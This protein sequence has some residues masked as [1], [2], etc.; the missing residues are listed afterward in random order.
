M[1][2]VIGVHAWSPEEA[3]EAGKRWQSGY[4]AWEFTNVRPVTVT[5][6]AVARRHIYPLALA[7]FYL[8]PLN[9]PGKF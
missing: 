3:A 7:K 1:I 6:K 2:D 9:R 4:Y 5:I 8:L